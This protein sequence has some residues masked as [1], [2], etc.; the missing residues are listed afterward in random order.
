[1]T[2]ALLALSG[3]AWLLSWP[4]IDLWPMSFLWAALLIRAVLGAR[5]L[6]WMGFVCL[7]VYSLC[8]AWLLRWVIEVSGPGYPVMA[9]Y[10]A[11]WMVLF[12][13]VYRR[14]AV[15]GF[16]AS[17]PQSVAAPVIWLAIEYLRAEIVL[18]AWPWYLAGMPLVHWPVLAQIADLGG[19]WMVGLLVM[20]TGTALGQW[21]M[22]DAGNRRPIVSTVVAS[23]ALILSVAYGYWR[24]LPVD[25]PEL[26]HYLLVQTNLPQDN[27][28]GWSFAQQ[29]EDLPAFMEMTRQ[30]LQESGGAQL[31]IWPETTVPGPGF[32]PDN[33]EFFDRYQDA[34]R[35]LKHWPEQ[36]W[37]FVHS[38]ETPML[39]GT[40]TWSGSVTIEREGDQGWFVPE[41][42]YNSATL[43]KPGGSVSSYHKVF[44]TP[45]G[46][47]LPWIDSWPWLRDQ[48]L[49]L[50]ARGMSLSL[51]PGPYQ[52]NISLN[53]NE[54]ETVLATPICFEATVPSVTRSLIRQG[55]GSTDL[56]VNLS[57]D[58]WFGSVDGGRLQHALAS[59]FRC[60]EWRQP[61]LRVANTG[62][63]AWYDSCG[64][65]MATLP[66]RTAG[67]LLATPQGDGRR[68]LYGIIGNTIPIICLITMALSFVLGFRR[69]Q[70]S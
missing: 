29:Q 26:G 60:I 58:G 45:F 6:W 34:A 8:W 36:L 12:V 46:E 55:G 61:M 23:V 19:V 3:L 50:G 67:T 15:H 22:P 57:N 68:T 2:A 59:R 1:M 43:L 4:P 18:G 70:H 51:D 7:L 14:L 37:R 56:L 33:A 21:M 52:G 38:I 39:V 5:N 25:S 64:R 31:V 11:V 53:Q 35:F 44:P 62:Q 32:D 49:E 10:S 42:Q 41:F 24:M 13:M 28:I 27:K 30:G 47:R 40:N 66:A 54:M 9:I 63:T 17:L 48:L 16:L 65:E 20:S 69:E